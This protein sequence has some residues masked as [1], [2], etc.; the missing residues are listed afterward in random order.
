MVLEK[1]IV[2]LDEIF[3]QGYRIQE[4]EIIDMLLPGL[5]QEVLNISL[6]QKQTDAGEK[7]RFKALVV[8]GNYDGYIGLG[9]G[10]AKQVRTAIEKAT[11]DAKLNI[12]PIR[13]GCG[14]WECGCGENHSL[15]F[16]VYGKCG[17]VRVEIIPAPKGVGIAAG[18]VAK[19]II[20]FAGVKDCW[21]KSFGSTRTI[22]SFAN[23]IY[24]ALR[25]TYSVLTPMDWS[26]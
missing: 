9:T 6:V 1:K 19:T 26:R 14:S 10:K 25:S 15:P 13:R 2:S 12:F 24:N 4:S 23:A 21:T 7:S 18:E 11:V 5:Q 20:A 17:S 22:L 3:S 16:K 8:V